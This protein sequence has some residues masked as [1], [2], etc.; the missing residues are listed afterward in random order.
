MGQAQATDILSAPSLLPL[1][2]RGL[3]WEH[4][5]A[6]VTGEGEL[7]IEDEGA[8]IPVKAKYEGTIT[9]TVS[10][11]A[12][13]YKNKV[14]IQAGDFGNEV[15]AK[16]KAGTIDISDCTVTNASG[17]TN[18]TETASMTGSKIKVEIE[19]FSETVDG[20]MVFSEYEAK[21]KVDYGSEN[22]IKLELKN[23]S[24]S[25]IPTEPPPTGGGVGTCTP[26]ACI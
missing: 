3:A 14:E 1:E 26:P 22:R 4:P 15:E 12:D 19:G 23:G 7:K 20:T 2:E 25:T 18:V 10:A 5:S 6:T 9:C 24:L 13:H 11:S 16:S 21:G 8:N 17:T